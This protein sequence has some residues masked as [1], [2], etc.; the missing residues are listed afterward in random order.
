M[1]DH[2]I[3]VK[4]LSKK[5]KGQKVLKEVTM[6]IHWREDHKSWKPQV[7]QSAN[8]SLLGFL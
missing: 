5:F 1:E 6:K 2:I 7:Y 4:N 3:V 8:Q